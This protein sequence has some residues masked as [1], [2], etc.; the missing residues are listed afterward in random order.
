MLRLGEWPALSTPLDAVLGLSR[1]IMAEGT[2]LVQIGYRGAHRRE[3]PIKCLR[4]REV[5][6]GGS[7]RKIETL[8]LQG[9]Q[10]KNHKL[11]ERDLTTEDSK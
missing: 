2:L 1:V 10:I 6:A 7:F 11:L 4:D 3:H 9:F 8:V 5:P